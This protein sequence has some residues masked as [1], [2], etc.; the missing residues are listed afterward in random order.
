MTLSFRR[1]CV[2]SLAV[3]VATLAVIPSVVAAQTCT[4]QF[5]LVGFSSSSMKGSSGIFRMT[6]ACQVDFEAS[7]ICTSEEVM[8]TVTIPEL[9]AQNAWVRPAIKP[10]GAGVI[11][12]M[13]DA[14]GSDSADGRSSSLPGDLTCRGWTTNND[15]RGLTVSNK[16]GFLTQK[17]DAGRPVACC[18]MIRVPEPPLAA[19]QGGAVAALAALARARK[20]KARRTPPDLIC[21]DQLVCEESEDPVGA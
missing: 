10:I 3:A 9:S 5:Q 6:E 8:N 15:Y 14:S 16:G 17:C 1:G 13:A 18:A 7:R 20:A 4:K 12:I 11:S 2:L 21:E 19:I